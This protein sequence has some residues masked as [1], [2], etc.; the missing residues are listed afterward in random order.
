MPAK[1]PRVYPL[2]IDDRELVDKTFDKLHKQERMSWS[3][4]STPF[5]YP[6]FVVWKTLPSRKRKGRVVIDIRGLNQISRIDVYPLPLQSD[7]LAAAQGCKYITVV[8]CASFF[9]QWR[10]H[11]SDRHKLTVISH[12]GQEYFNVCVLGFKNS[13]AYVQ[14]RIDILLR[15]Y[16]WAHAYIDDVV[17]ASRTLEEHIHHLQTVFSVFSSVGISINPSK[18]FIGFPSIRLLG[19]HVDSLGLSTAA[20]KLEA[21]ASLE[22][23]TTLQQLET[24]LGLTGY[25][26]QYVPFYAAVSGPLQ[27]RKALLLRRG[28]SAGPQ[29]K[30]FSLKTLLESPTPAEVESWKSLQE[31]LSNPQY[32]VHFD[33]SR[34]L[35]ADVDASKAFGFGA[36]IY[37]VKDDALDSATATYPRKSSIEPIMFLSRQLSLV[38]HWY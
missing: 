17:I 32:L 36:V 1:A 30:S 24:Y 4:T 14:R 31:L 5:S 28:P 33:P 19:Q 15:D 34:R 22:F 23:P 21:I 12:C 26:R 16:P 8:D 10:V 35:Y 29:R 9:Y 13:P 18:A 3:T 38:E 20:E 7:V 11:P 27:D 2:G 6:V 25:L 37:H